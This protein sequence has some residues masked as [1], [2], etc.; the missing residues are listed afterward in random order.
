[1][2]IGIDLSFIR[3]DHKN[4]GTEAVMK[5]LIKGF[6]ELK[7]SGK[8]TDDFIYFIHRDIYEDYHKDFPNLVYRIYD[9]KFP[10]ALRMIKFQTFDLPK[11][12]AKEKLD[13]LYFPTFQTGLG[14]GWKLPLVVN[15]HDIQYKYYPEY[16]SLLKR[17]YFQVFYG[18]SLKKA[19]KVVAIS[20]YVAGS[21]KK[22]FRKYVKGKLC[23]IYDP[24]DFEMKQEEAPD[25]LK[26]ISSDYILCVNSLAKHK[27]L[28]T[29][30][31]AF[32]MLMEDPDISPSLKLVIA[33]ASWNGANE[34]SDY[35]EKNHL[36]DRIILTGYLTEGQLQYLYHRAKVFVTPSLY[37]G[38]GMTPIE[39]MAAGCPVISSKETS[40]Y[41]VTMGK[42]YYYE[43]AKDAGALCKAMS[44]MIVG[45]GDLRE[46]MK[47]VL[48]E[49]RKAV[50]RY[51][52][53]KIARQYIKLFYEAA[54]EK[55]QM[56]SKLNAD[57]GQKQVNDSEGKAKSQEVTKDAAEVKA[58]RDT[59]IYGRLFDVV[60]ENGAKSGR[61]LDCARESFE[62]SIGCAPRKIN[63][64]PFLE[65]K[66]KKFADALW[67]GF[68]QKL[69]S[70]QKAKSFE[71]K[72][73]SEI[74]KAAAGEGAFA[75]RGIR[76]LNSPYGDIKP[77]AKGR[78]LQGVSSVKNSVFL[79]QL[80]KKMPAGIQNR[81]RGLFC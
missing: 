36:G 39:A 20:R 69:P 45:H 50:L 22:Y 72:N 34:I 68:F 38:F 37:E 71:K 66:G 42:A 21:Y 57:K 24:I 9:T 79:R 78:I 58:E 6:E 13:L 59:E 31:K 56:K 64:H 8:I 54:E 32:H 41:E 70:R 7:S 61:P 62:A 29:L 19:D 65:L 53:G 1:M 55:K 77:G 16:F 43:P 30:V 49:N 14:C 48:E 10:H 26:G 11:L 44:G 12:S 35:I 2:R 27:N 76:P 60:S 33:G 3:P 40:L 23:L 17:C 18:N 15:P 67:L 63:L 25:A 80:A 47:E 73:R 28:I 81:I 5:N 75:I 46:D 4:G 51:S 74:L 52:K